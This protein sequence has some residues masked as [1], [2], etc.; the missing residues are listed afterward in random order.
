MSGLDKDLPN[1]SRISDN[2]LLC[3]CQPA[4]HSPTMN[5]NADADFLSIKNPFL[6]YSS[7]FLCLFVV[8]KM[9]CGNL[10]IAEL[11]SACVSL[12]CL[13]V[14]SVENHGA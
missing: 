11:T 9:V 7:A 14:G 4:A 5:I 2:E 8:Q 1:S 10:S 6:V 12:L 3:V 13:S